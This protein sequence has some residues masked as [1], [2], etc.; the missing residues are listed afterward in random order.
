LLQAAEEAEATRRETEELCQ[1]ALAIVNKI[2]R[3]VHRDTAEFPALRQCYAHA[4][5]LRNVIAAA[6]WTETPSEVQALAQGTHPL[7]VLLMFVERYEDLDDEQWEAFHTTIASSFEQSL[8]TAVLRQRLLLQGDSPI[9]ESTIPS[10]PHE[11][12]VALVCP[13]P[14]TSADETTLSLD[15]PAQGE[16]AE[17]SE[18][19]LTKTEEIQTNNEHTSQNFL[20]EAIVAVAEDRL[21]E[22]EAGDIQQTP[23]IDLLTLASPPQGTLHDCTNIPHAAVPQTEVHPIMQ[24]EAEEEPAVGQFPFCFGPTDTA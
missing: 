1:H 10:V 12:C 7:A 15:T 6:S 8:V 14:P 5:E 19:P 23:E 18:I 11:E 13:F 24:V 3:I 17:K 22:T 20:M 21:H 4:Y 9:Q 2:L 16:T